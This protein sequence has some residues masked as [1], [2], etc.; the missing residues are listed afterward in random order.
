MQP[1]NR[2]NCECGRTL[3]AAAV[4]LY[5]SNTDICIFHRCECGAEWTEHR[6]SDPTEPISS[7]EVI[8]VHTRLASF[9]GSMAELFQ[10]HPAYPA[11]QSTPVPARAPIAGL[12]RLRVPAPAANLGGGGFSDPVDR[13]HHT[14]ALVLDVIEARGLRN[15]ARLC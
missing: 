12:A 15:A 5:R 14:R 8:E 3:A 1:R 2:A 7:D 9:E 4:Y 13:A 11:R 10:P 6:D